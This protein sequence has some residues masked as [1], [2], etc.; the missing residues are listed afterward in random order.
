MSYE[1]IS[2]KVDP[3]T[4]KQAQNAAEE[5]GLS[6]S[7]VVKGF[8]KQFIRTKTVTFSARD[9]EIPNEYFIKTLAK[10]RKNRKEGKGSPIF[11][12]GEETVKWLEEQGI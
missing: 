9:E 11:R 8:L 5:L 4:K 3:A 1:V 10:A 12:T 6:L 2:I 7:S